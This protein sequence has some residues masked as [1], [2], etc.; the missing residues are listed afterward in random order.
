M[1][2]HLEDDAE[3]QPSDTGRREGGDA[4]EHRVR[5][6][7][8]HAPERVGSWS[9]GEAQQP[10]DQHGAETGENDRRHRCSS[11]DTVRGYLHVF[12]HRCTLLVRQGGSAPTLRTVRWEGL[13]ADLEGQLAAEER[14]ELDSEVAERTRRERALVDLGARLGASTGAALVVHLA[15]GRRVEGTLSDHGDG[16]L[17]LA[18]S[19]PAGPGA[20]REVLVPMGGVVALT[21][22]SPGAEP[23]RAGRRFGL[24]Y[25]L[26]VL[27]RDRATAALWLS[28]GGEL[29][30]TV[31]VVGADHLVLAEHPDGE[32]RRWTNVR[33]LVTVPVAALLAVESRR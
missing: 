2:Q 6:G 28:G 32:P 18:V 22:L 21:G 16:W 33:R 29:A 23:G 24:G 12:D 3:E 15:G 30:G 20:A 19:T 27:A 4:G 31:D 13:F 14:R 7:Y 5:R 1:G 25:A 8:G 11:F 17:L 26:R 10:R 9:R